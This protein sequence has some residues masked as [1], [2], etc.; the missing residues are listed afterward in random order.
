MLLSDFLKQTLPS[1]E[2]KI[3]ISNGQIKLNSEPITK[4]IEVGI[5][6]KFEEWIKNVDNKTMGI[7]HSLS[8]IQPLE[9]W[10]SPEV[11]KKLSIFNEWNIL[12][13]TKKEFVF[14]QK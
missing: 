12:K 2:V 3:R 7:I 10:F 8:K 11:D 9:N 1:K 6:I 4:D 5:P 13:I 14:Y